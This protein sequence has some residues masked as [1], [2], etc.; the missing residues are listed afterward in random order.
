MLVF[1]AIQHT[2]V[3]TQISKNSSNYQATKPQ[4]HSLL[5]TWSLT[6]SL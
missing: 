2:A 6:L 5:V 4:F 3:S 1:T